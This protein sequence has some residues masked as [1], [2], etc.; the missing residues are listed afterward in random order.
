M[1]KHNLSWLTCSGT[2]EWFSENGAS[3]DWLIPNLRIHL[4]TVIVFFIRR[5]FSE[6]PL[7]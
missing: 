2:N 4:I 3:K 5:N 7:S 6:T 1:G